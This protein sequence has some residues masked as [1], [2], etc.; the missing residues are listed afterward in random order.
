MR[1]IDYISSIIHI[2][3]YN[4]IINKL[5]YYSTIAKI[6]YTELNEGT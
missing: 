5:Y 6:V 2:I 1:K 3:K 4:I